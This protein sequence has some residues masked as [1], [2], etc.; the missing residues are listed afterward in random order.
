MAFY[1]CYLWFLSDIVHELVVLGE[2]YGDLVLGFHL[3]ERIF[4]CAFLGFC[5][6]CLF[7]FFR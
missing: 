2:L 1:F 3:V 6:I 7:Y 5:P 4:G